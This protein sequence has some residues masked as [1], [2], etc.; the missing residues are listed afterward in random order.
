MHASKSRL[1][2]VRVTGL[3]LFLHHCPKE[4]KPKTLNLSAALFPS[5]RM[6]AEASRHKP[7]PELNQTSMFYIAQRKS[8]CSQEAVR[9]PGISNFTRASRASA[10]TAHHG[11]VSG[12]VYR[13]GWTH[14]NSNCK[15]HLRITAN[16]KAVDLRPTPVQTPATAH[17]I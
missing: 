2:G 10:T 15:S 1:W 8:V 6:T 14:L 16:T 3:G 13:T 9:H 17:A 4:N 7:G 11:A 5:N 12:H